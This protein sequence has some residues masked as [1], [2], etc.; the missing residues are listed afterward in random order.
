MIHTHIRDCPNEPIII[1]IYHLVIDFCGFDRDN[2]KGLSKSVLQQTS[3]L[4]IGATP[5]AEKAPYVQRDEKNKN[6][7]LG[8]ALQLKSSF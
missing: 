3:G 8:P 2:T 1:V 4:R 5:D 6:Q 7:K